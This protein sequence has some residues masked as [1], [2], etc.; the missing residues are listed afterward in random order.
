MADLR[1]KINSENVDLKKLWKSLSYDEEKDLSFEEF[2]NFLQTINP[3]ISE[4]E[5]IYF[6]EKMDANGDGSISLKELEEEFQKYSINLTSKYGNKIPLQVRKVNSMM[7][8]SEDSIENGSNKTI[9]W[10]EEF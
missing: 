7:E 8:T 10:D 2:Q 9:K 5:E 3:D 6:F 1:F 4:A